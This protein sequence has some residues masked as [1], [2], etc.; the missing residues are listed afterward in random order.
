MTRKSELP[1]PAPRVCALVSFLFVILPSGVIDL[2]NREPPSEAPV[3]RWVMGCYG[4]ANLPISIVLLPIALYIPTFYSRDLGLSLTAV[5]VLLTL[6][7]LTDVLTDPV[8]GVLSD[9]W[10]TRFGRRKP[11]ILVGTP[12]MMVSLWMLFVPPLEVT[13]LH[14]FVWISLLY[15]AYTLVDLPYH[16]WGAELSPDYR[17][18]SRVTGWREGFGYVGLIAALAIPLYVAFGLEMPGPRNALFGIAVAVVVALPL[19]VAPLLLFVR[20]PDLPRLE[21]RQLTWA[22]GLRVVWRNGPFRR[23][24]LCFLFFVG[25]ISMTASL[26]FFFVQHVMEEPFERYAVFVLA[27]YLSSTAAIPIWLRISDRLGKHRTV[28]LGIAWLSFWSAWIPLLGPGDYG[29]FFFLMVMKGSSVGAL[30]FLPASMAADIVD[31]D[32]LRSGEQR[33]GLYFSIWGMV[34]KG[35]AALGVLCS[36][37]AAAWFGFDPAIDTNTDTAKLAVAC[38]YSVVPAGLALIAV[39]LLW[40]YPLTEARQRRLRERIARRNMQRSSV[41]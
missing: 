3:A 21:R 10:R 16:A 30:Y 11:W 9:R 35:A 33:T 38:L 20:E 23:V 8:I 36:T 2:P 15:L 14:L 17:E 31:L 40:R 37:T 39:P 26:S 34:L 29:L 5:G 32:T 18:R 25:A 7:R 4:L 28:V 1:H 19:M 13:T 24:V 22:Q 27:Y 12:L 6:S 41:S